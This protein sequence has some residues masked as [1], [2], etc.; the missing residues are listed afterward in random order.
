MRMCDFYQG[1]NSLNFHEP[2]VTIE[3]RMLAI[4]QN[5]APDGEDSHVL[6][7]SHIERL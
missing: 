2:E 7:H 4:Q 5:I 3:Y 1:N 6:V